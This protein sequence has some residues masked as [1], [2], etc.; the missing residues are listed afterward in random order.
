MKLKLKQG[1]KKTHVKELVELNGAVLVG[2]DLLDE[3]ANPVAWDVLL[4]N[5]D[6]DLANLLGINVTVAV[7]I[8]GVE[9]LPELSLLSLSEIGGGGSHFAF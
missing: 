5:A 2:I 7:S 3:L 1:R 6:E 8:E 9:D 4:T